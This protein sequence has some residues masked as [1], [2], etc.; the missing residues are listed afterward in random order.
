MQKISKVLLGL[1]LTATTLLGYEKYFVV[2]RES[3]SLAVIENGIKYS[4]IENMHNMNHGVVKFEGKDG[5]VISRDGFV[6]KF[7]P[8]SE[9]ILGEYKTSKSAIG[10][11]I[12]KHYVAVANYDDQSV[13]ILDRDL[14]PIKK[15]QNTF[16]KCWY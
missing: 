7:D 10:F 3:E 16:K 9:K 2:E 4:K 6:V 1:A 11:V 15:N 8:V 12:G 5:Y 13:D 14:N